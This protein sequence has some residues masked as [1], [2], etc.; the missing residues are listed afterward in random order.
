LWLALIGCATITVG[1]MV[2]VPLFPVPF[3]LQTMAVFIVALTQTPK[4][5]ALSC[6]AYLLAASIGLPVLCGK[7]NP[8]W[9]A[10]KCGG[11]LVAF[12]LAAFVT[13]HLVRSCSPLVALTVGQLIIYF[14]GWCWLAPLFSAQ[15]AFLKGVLLFIP[16]DI[17]KNIFAV[18]VAAMWHSH[19]N[20]GKQGK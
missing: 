13:A 19:S 18:R 20:S 14:F 6:I 16:S 3:T 8:L 17:V 7:S 9:I 4:Q 1:S 15:E 2:K 11:Y 5:A 10:G 12:P